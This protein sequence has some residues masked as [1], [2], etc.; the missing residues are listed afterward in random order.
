M[1]KAPGY[2]PEDLFANKAFVT[3]EAAA[4]GRCLI[5]RFR[6]FFIWQLDLFSLDFHCVAVRPNPGTM[7][8]DP[9]DQSHPI[10]AKE[11]AL[12]DP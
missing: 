8:L 9:S 11:H 5:T 6:F 7:S 12:G 4:I 10:S 2:R 1:A 3:P